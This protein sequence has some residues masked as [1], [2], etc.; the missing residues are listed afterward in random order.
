MI[1]EEFLALDTAGRA[2]LFV[3]GYCT[4]CD[5]V[6]TKQKAL[7]N[8]YGTCS[9]QCTNIARGVT[10]LCSCDHCGNSFFRAKSKITKSKSGKLFC[11][12]ECKNVA[13][14]YML[15][16]QPSHYGQGI[17]RYRERGLKHYGATCARCGY[18]GNSTALVVHHKDRNRL[19]GS[20]ENL[21]VLCANCHA[22]EHHSR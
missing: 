12:K 10:L 22:I 16:I 20:L 8:N 6:Y 1:I 3:R 19:N 11:C 9:L 18:S 2:R 4:V 15:E 17:T 7:L 21:E 5:A 14:T 13:Q